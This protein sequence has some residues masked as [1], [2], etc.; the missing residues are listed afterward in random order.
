[1]SC[2][3][4]VRAAN[5]MPVALVVFAAAAL[6]TAS[7]ASMPCLNGT[8]Y[9]LPSGVV[10]QSAFTY[11]NCA[12]ESQTAYDLVNLAERVDQLIAALDITY[13]FLCASLVFLMQLGFAMLEVGCVSDKNINNIILKG[14]LDIVIAALFF[15][16]FGW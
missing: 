9:L 2:D 5:L 6:P 16:A 15:W 12:Y 1:M 13:Y 3:M 8:S 11:D 14:T 7:A 4:A 10:D